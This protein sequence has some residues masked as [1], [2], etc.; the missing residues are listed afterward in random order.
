MAT[1]MV[2]WDGAGHV[3]EFRGKVEL[4][5]FLGTKSYSQMAR[6]LSD[7]TPLRGWF[8]DEALTDGTG[9]PLEDALMDTTIQ[10]KKAYQRKLEAG[11]IYE[12]RG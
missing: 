11:G 4:L 9:A 10:A 8:I 6:A 7:G 1:R 3:K 2:A 5:S 12:K